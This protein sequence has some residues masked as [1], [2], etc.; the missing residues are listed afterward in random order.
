MLVRLQGFRPCLDFPREDRDLTF[1]RKVGGFGLSNFDLSKDCT[2]PGS[3][4]W[5]SEKDAVH[6]VERSGFWV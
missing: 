4:S 6:D 1:R 2:D 3:R 5:K